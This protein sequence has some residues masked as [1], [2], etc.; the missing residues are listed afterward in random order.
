MTSPSIKVPSFAKINR[1]LKVLGKRQDGFHEIVTVF[2]TISLFDELTF[3]LREDLDLAISC[4]NPDIPVDKHNLVWRAAERLRQVSGVQLGASINLIKRIPVQAGLGGGSSNAAVTLLALNELWRTNLSRSEL[5]AIAATVGS[6]V[7]FF[8][9]GGTC[10]GEGTGNRISS[11]PDGP[12][13]PLIVITP[14]AG[15]STA[16]AYNALNASSLTT[17]GS[18]SIL[19]RSFGAPIR[20]K[21]GRW[22][23]E[24]DFERV[25][26]EIEPEIKRVKLALLEAGAR[27]AL[28][29]GS[30]SSVFGIFSDEE[31]RAQAA[32]DLK[33]E[34]GWRLFS[35]NTLPKDEY[36][37]SLQSAGHPFL[38]SLNLQ[39]DTG[40]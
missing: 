18:T 6:D 23:L 25:I 21:P 34:T 20:E 16:K 11:L 1:S 15:V 7:P 28:L 3:V 27:G 35:C 37:R 33:S 39:P 9:S 13:E 24:N 8:L 10:L 31:A 32:A 38:R 12:V 19:A 4:N 30:G 2:Q 36:I 5:F 40:A 29:A 17:K 14:P 26:F 22:A